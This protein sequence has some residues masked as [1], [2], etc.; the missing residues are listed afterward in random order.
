MYDV[1]MQVIN[2][3]IYIYTDLTREPVLFSLKGFMARA[4]ASETKSTSW[5]LPT[6]VLEAAARQW[7]WYTTWD[8]AAM[9]GNG[10]CI[11]GHGKC[12]PLWNCRHE[13]GKSNL[14]PKIETSLLC[15]FETGLSSSKTIYG[16]QLVFCKRDFQWAVLRNQGT[17]LFQSHHLNL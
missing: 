4:L 13:G 1:C 9:L 7:D 2:E 12:I 6:S 11:F 16:N 8:D 3:Y 10:W 14:S 17:G 15:N 5:A